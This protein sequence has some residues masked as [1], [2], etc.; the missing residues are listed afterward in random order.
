MKAVEFPNAQPELLRFLSTL[1]VILV[2]HL[3]MILVKKRRIIIIASRREIFIHIL[4]RRKKSTT[5][6]KSNNRINIIST[7][8]KHKQKR[9]TVR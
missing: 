5:D 7:T 9:K 8:F 6:P 3:L 2:P 4:L 1:P